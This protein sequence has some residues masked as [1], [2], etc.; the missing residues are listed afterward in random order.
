M[1]RFFRVFKYDS[2]V[3]RRN[4]TSGMTAKLHD[5]NCT[6]NAVESKESTLGIPIEPIAFSFF[7]PAKVM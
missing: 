3:Q 5:S 6:R 2:S 4:R 1:L 7:I